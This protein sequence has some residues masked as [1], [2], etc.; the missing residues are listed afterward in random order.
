MIVVEQKT[1]D[2]KGRFFMAEL[3]LQQIT[4]R[5]NSELCGENRKIVFWYDDNGEFAEDIES[6]EL[7]HAKILYL[8]KDNQFYI[9]HFLE[10]VDTTTHYLVYAPFPKPDIRYNHLEDTVRY[11]KRFFITLELG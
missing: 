6:I 2:N 11:S 10:R 5:L 9:K 8:E 7:A 4:D 1:P 3:N